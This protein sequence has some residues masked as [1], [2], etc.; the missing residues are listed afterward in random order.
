V[1]SCITIRRRDA[2]IAARR[3]SSRCRLFPPGEQQVGHIGAH[4]QQDEDDCA[5]ERDEIG[6]CRADCFV[7]KGVDVWRERDRRVEI[8][9]VFAHDPAREASRLYTQFVDGDARSQPADAREVMVDPSIRFV[10]HKLR[11]GFAGPLGADR[12]VHLRI[13]VGILERGRHHADDRALHSVERKRL[14]NDGTVGGEHSCPQR[15]AQHDYARRTRDVG[16]AEASAEH[17]L[18]TQR[19][20]EVRRRAHQAN[21]LRHCFSGE[22]ALRSAECGEGLERGQVIAI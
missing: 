11:Q 15:V 6:L 5:E 4:D 16:F 13:A 9:C 21:A 1:S 12:Q 3:A 2:P 20:E 14:P 17:R 8:L 10:R 22:V 7:A 19:G 18:H